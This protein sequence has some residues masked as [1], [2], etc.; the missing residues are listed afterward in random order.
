MMG[1]VEHTGGRRKG[2][3]QMQLRKVIP[4]YENKCNSLD[5]REESLAKELR[6]I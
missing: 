1:M 5:V 6:E 4:Q 3:W 2:N